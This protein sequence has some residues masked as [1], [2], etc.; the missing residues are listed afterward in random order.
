MHANRITTLIKF[1]LTTAGQ[2]EPG[3]RELGPIHVLKYIYLA[4]LLYAERHEGETFTEA[5]W[6]FYHYG[7]WASP[8][9]DAIQEVVKLVG[10]RERT[11]T[12]PK[13]EGDSTR[14]Q[15]VDDDIHQEAARALPIEIKG[16]LSR[17]IHEYGSDTTSLL[18]MVYRT[19]PMLRAAPGERLD[20]TCVYQEPDVAHVSDTDVPESKP[21][22]EKARRRRKEKL[23]AMRTKFKELVAAKT[24]SR[25]LVSPSPAPRYDE[26]FH[27]GLQWLD[28][29]AGDPIEA[30][31][32]TLIISE[33]IWKSPGRDDQD[34]S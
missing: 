31:E 11:F 24:A 21:L 14:W 19:R 15:L 27:E 8:V 5:E 32:G 18:H 9:H 29:L 16:R 6:T 22:S 20:L 10:V 25:Q 34:V 3:N 7:P 1:I 12:S 33:D 28:S 26:Q 13:H 30:T 4:D 2:E 17:T 23:D